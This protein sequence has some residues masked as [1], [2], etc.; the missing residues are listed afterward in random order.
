MKWIEVKPEEVSKLATETDVILVPIGCIESHGPHMPSGADGYMAEA[1]AVEAAKIEK[2]LVFPTLYMNVCC[3]G[4]PLP[5]VEFQL[6]A[7]TVSFPFNLMTD[8]IKQIAM[9]AA[10][11]GF[12]KVLCVAGHAPTRGPLVAAQS[13]IQEE[14][15][16]L[17]AMGK[18]VPILFWTDL[19]ALCSQTGK[20]LGLDIEHAGGWETALTAAAV[21]EF[22][23]LEMAKELPPNEDFPSTIKG[24]T[25]VHNWPKTAP[26]GYQG[27]PGDATVELGKKSLKAGAEAL[28][29]LIKSLREYDISR[30]I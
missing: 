17:H 2:A 22:V 13:E 26:N 8:I 14:A 7:P 20:E 10:R 19:W 16:A 12:P 24:L 15:Q 5:G 21:P 29:N 11:L 3:A 4:K 27:R 30:D 9:E 28:A 6:K 18:A 1:V 25:Y 23:D